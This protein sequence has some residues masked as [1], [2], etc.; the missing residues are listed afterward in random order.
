MNNCVHR[1]LCP[2]ECPCDYYEKEKRMKI[3][4]DPGNNTN[5]EKDDG[6]KH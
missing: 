5:T 2:N 3:K 6:E 1:K 4:L